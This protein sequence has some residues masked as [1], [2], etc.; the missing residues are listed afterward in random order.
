VHFSVQ[1]HHL[2]LIVEARDAEALSHGV[3]G[4]GVRLARRINTALDRRGRVFVDR[5][6]PRVLKTPRQTRAALAYVLLN[7]RRHAAQSGQKLAWGWI[8]PC[9][10]GSTFDGWR[11]RPTL[12]R[13]PRNA[14][15]AA[16]AVAP[17]TWLLAVGW[18]RHGLID[19]NVVPGAV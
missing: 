15:A 7:S 2:H 4:L 11:S 1:C 12:P 5:Y 14:S 16:I 19:V 13:A 8:D 9:S 17:G 6:F 18:R 3:R 10:S